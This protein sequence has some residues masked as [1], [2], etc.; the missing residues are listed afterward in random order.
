M[1]RTRTL[2]NARSAR[3]QL[4]GLVDE[5]L[6]SRADLAKTKGF[7]A[8]W[9]KGMNTR[10]IES[11]AW[12]LLL[13]STLEKLDRAHEIAMMQ[14]KIAVEVIPG[15]IHNLHED[16]PVKVALVVQEYLRKLHLTNHTCDLVMDFRKGLT[17]AERPEAE[18]AMALRL[19]EGWSE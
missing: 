10:F 3:I 14:G 1:I 5:K 18:S 15:C 12:K 4:P 17:D 19:K 9:F 7:W 6:D 8:G 16:Q 13:V 11:A 2:M